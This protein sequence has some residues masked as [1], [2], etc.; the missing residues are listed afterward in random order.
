MPRRSFIRPSGFRDSRLVVIASEGSNTEPMYFEAIRDSLLKYPSR[1]HI[2]VLRREA[3][4]SAPEHVIRQ[5]DVFRKT[6][7]LSAHDELWAVI[8]FDRWGEEKLSRIAAAAIQ[9]G[10]RL[11]VSRPCFELWR[12]LHFQDL[13]R[14]P[15]RELEDIALEDCKALTKRVRRI[16]GTCSKNMNNVEEYLPNTDVAIERAALLDTNPQERWPSSLGTRIYRII[17][18]I[19]GRV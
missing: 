18:S 17:Q 3:G 2:E 15:V 5:L 14:L 8:D 4:P 12:L 1:V 19:R 10:Y 13:S 6:W 11:A 9:K 16:C 7:N